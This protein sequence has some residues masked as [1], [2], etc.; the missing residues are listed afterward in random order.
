MGPDSPVGLTIRESAARLGISENAVRK[1]IQ[2]GKL[3]ATKIDGVWRL[4]LPSDVHESTTL[5]TIPDD[6]ASTVQLQRHIEQQ[7]AEIEFLRGEVTAR[8]EAERELR[9][10]I[11]QLSERLPQLPA[12]A[13]ANPRQPRSWWQF[14]RR[15]EREPS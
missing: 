5:L 13:E 15:T 6:S 11:V 14:W 4:T 7:L 10:I 2:R 12:R 1:Q 3:D 8:R 9:V